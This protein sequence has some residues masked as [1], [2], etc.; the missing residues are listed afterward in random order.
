MHQI[1]RFDGEHFFLSNFYPCKV[2]FDEQFYNSSEH[3]YQA[4]K[5][6]DDTI[7]YKFRQDIKSL[8]AKRMGKKIKLRKDWEA[9]KR[10][11]MEKIVL[12][13][14]TRNFDLRERLLQTGSLE[15]IEGN[16]WNDTYWG[17]CNGQ[18]FN[19]LGRIL[20]KVRDQINII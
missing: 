16:T 7:R 19:H 11:I 18:G 17:V 5:T 8:E 3:A 14:F 20:M 15:L 10:N 1:N 9:V 13:K 12:D 4:A 6:L 2:R